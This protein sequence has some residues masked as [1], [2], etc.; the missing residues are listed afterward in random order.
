MS[1]ISNDTACGSTIFLV[2]FVV[3]TSSPAG[4][5]VDTTSL[6]QCDPFDT[7]LLLVVCK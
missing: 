3:K 2:A 4:D 5:I 7:T 6:V 1:M